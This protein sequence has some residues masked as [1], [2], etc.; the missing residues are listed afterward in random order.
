MQEV[1][2]SSL[3]SSTNKRPL[4]EGFFIFAIIISMTVIIALIL[5]A[6]GCFLYWFG[7]EVGSGKHKADPNDRFFPL[8][9][10]NIDYV[11]G[12][13][14]I[15][16]AIGIFILA[17]GVWSELRALNYIAAIFVLI[18]V[19]RA[20]APP[21]KF[22]PAWYRNKNTKPSKKRRSKSRKK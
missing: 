3:P 10:R 4:L 19:V 12:T 15:P 6:L 16:M 13:A 18:G 22:G 21:A 14:G 11:L 9:G 2:S 1:G 8:F 17:F 20:Y 5:V 7:Y